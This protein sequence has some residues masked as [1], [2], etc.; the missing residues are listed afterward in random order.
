MRVG[1]FQ[2]Y[3]YSI[4]NLQRRQV[5]LG[6]S[7]EQLTS[8]K[9][10]A[11]ASD[12][13]AAAARAERAL[14]AMSRSDAD[15]RA[16]EASRSAM[17]LTESA[18]GAAGDLMQQARE[19]IVA[20]GNAAYSDAERAMQAQVLQ[21]IRERLLAVAN[22]GDGAG[23]YLF[24]GQGSATPPFVDAPDAS[25]PW[26]RRVRYDGSAG[27]ARVTSAEPL[28]LAV[29]GR[30][31]WL[32]APNPVPTDPP[33][34]VFDALDRA[35]YELAT[36]GR[37]GPQVAATVQTGLSEL[38]AVY[39]HMLG[40]RASAGETLNRADGVEGRIADTKFSAQYER[41]LAEDLDMVQ[42]ISDF[43]NRQTGYDAALKAYSLVQRM[44]LFN[45]LGG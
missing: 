23:T 2:S 12:D 44:S 27:A 37:T 8:G 31:A 42:A 45:Y 13:P 5:E 20:A 26:G 25:V 18:F 38:D 19:A 9:R 36:P 41:S 43:Q 24:S 30:A 1:T 10:V 17:Q 7:Q 32:E 29:D 3:D 22:R 15:Q 21:G 35:I 40:Q 11:R 39:G 14:V 34:S 33:L 4:A 6:R 28:P 16:L